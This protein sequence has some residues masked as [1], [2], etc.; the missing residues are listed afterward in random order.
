MSPERAEE[1]RRLAWT[2]AGL[3]AALGPH[4]LRLQAWVTAFVLAACAWRL[5]AARRGWH[6]PPPLVRG[7]G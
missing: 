1:F 7:S 6:L 4:F 2:M 3:V 5:L